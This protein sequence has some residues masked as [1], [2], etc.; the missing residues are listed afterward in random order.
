MKNTPYSK[1]LT[2]INTKKVFFVD[3]ELANLTC[4]V[5]NNYIVD[6]WLVTILCVEL[7]LS[8]FNKLFIEIAANQ[9]DG[10]TTKAATH[11]T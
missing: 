4:S 9:V 1:Y 8:I 11:D 10:A 2:F 7:C 3:S 6:F 5:A